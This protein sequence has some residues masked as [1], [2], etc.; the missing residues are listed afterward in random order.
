MPIEISL[1]ILLVVSFAATRLNS[2]TIPGPS[3]LAVQ[4]VEKKI[5]QRNCVKITW[6]IS[7][8]VQLFIWKLISFPDC[9]KVYEE[10]DDGDGYLYY[11]KFESIYVHV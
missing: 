2:E 6:I 3:D 7:S 10:N 4:S 1:S 8:Y 5:Y 9:H 11:R